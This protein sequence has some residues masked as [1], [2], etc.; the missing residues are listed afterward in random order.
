MLIKQFFTNL[1]EKYKQD[2]GVELNLILFNSKLNSPFFFVLSLK[3]C[4]TKSAGECLR[5]VKKK[6]MSVGKTDSN[7]FE[8]TIGVNTLQ[9]PPDSKFSFFY[10]VCL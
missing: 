5:A 1:V 2:Q 4:K 6:I 3:F 7:T 9:F 8:A 10:F